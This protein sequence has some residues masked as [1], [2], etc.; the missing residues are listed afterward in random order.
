MRQTDD[1]LVIEP[2]LLHGGTFASYADHRMA[3]AAA[4][5]GLVVPDVVV[6]D[7]DCTAKTMPDFPRRW[8]AMIDDSQRYT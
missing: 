8:Q 7:I 4:L 6:D 2:R 1:G 5:L 3:H